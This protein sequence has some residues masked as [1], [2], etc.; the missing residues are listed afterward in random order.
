MSSSVKRKRTDSSESPDA[1]VKSENSR[2]DPY[3]EDE[4]GRSPKKRAVSRSQLPKN[5]VDT[6]TLAIKQKEEEDDNELQAVNEKIKG[7]V[8][9]E[10]EESRRNVRGPIC[11]LTHRLKDD[12]HPV[13]YSHILPRA[14]S[15]ET[16]D[17]LGWAWNKGKDEL[18]VHTHLNI[19]T[20]DVYYHRM[21]DSGYWFWLP[22][23][24]HPVDKMYRHYVKQGKARADPTIF[25]NKSETTFDYYYVPF[26]NR[27]NPIPI[28]RY[29]TMQIDSSI[30]IFEHPYEEFPSVTMHVQ[31]HFI[32]FDTGKKLYRKYG[33]KPI[34]QSDFPGVG[35]LFSSLEIIRDIYCA[36][37]DAKPD[38]NLS[39]SRQPASHTSL[40]PQSRQTRNTTRSQADRTPSQNTA[41]E[42]QGAG[43]DDTTSESQEAGH[44]SLGPLD[45]AS[46]VPSNAPSTS[47][48]DDEDEED[49][50]MDENWKQGITQWAFNVR[51]A[52][53]LESKG[54]SSDGSE[55]SGNSEDCSEN[56]DETAVDMP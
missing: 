30:E 2:F 3:A 45:S 11:V 37:K 14:T 12:G 10:I 4:T 32:I 28:I 38:W 7:V 49:E 31:P 16:L 5:K 24:T 9:S 15:S 18:W 25:Y 33:K 22:A 20:I 40:A 39:S 46:N 27:K 35:G 26:E 51:D 29:A 52:C 21:F 48:D 53:Q 42:S 41:S 47:L 43:Y 17:F 6:K 19:Q 13:E 55:T 23:K 1:A 56:S 50:V 8:Q 36:W 34:L 54:Y 44:D